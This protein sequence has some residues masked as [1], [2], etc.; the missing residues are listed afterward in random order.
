MTDMKLAVVPVVDEY[1]DAAN[2]TTIEVDGVYGGVEGGY[3][4]SSFDKGK[5]TREQI[6]TMSRA[7]EP[8]LWRTVSDAQDGQRLAAAT[9][10]AEAIERM[11]AAVKS[12]GFGVEGE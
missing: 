2:R 3:F 7:A 9:L 8:H 5:L 12:V 10:A 6:E 4:L 11:I 1:V